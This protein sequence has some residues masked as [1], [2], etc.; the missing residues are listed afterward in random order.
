MAIPASQIVQVNPRLLTPGGTDLEFNGLFITNSD[1]IPS[2]QMVVPFGTPD[3]VGEYFGMDSDEYKMSVIY[4]QGYNNS[5]KKPRAIYFGRR[6]AENASAF[7]RGSSFK[8]LPA[9]TLA[10]LQKITDGGFTLTMDGATETISNISLKSAASLSDVAQIIQTAIREANTANLAWSGATVTYSSIFNA[11][12]VTTGSSGAESAVSFMSAPSATEE[13][14]ITDLS[15]ALRMTETAGA[16]QSAGMNAMT[17]AENMAAFLDLTENF[18]CLTTLKQPTQEDALDYAAWASGQGVNYLYIYWDND[19][20]LLQPNNETT[21]AAALKAAN[22]GATCGVW[23]KCDHAAF[24]MGVAA[25]I[26]WE[27]RNGTITFA[28]KSQD[29][30]A[31]NVETGTNA[32]NLTAQGMNFMGDYATRNDQFIFLYPGQMFGSW[33]WIDTY[34]NAVWLNNVLQVSLMNGLSQSP[35]TP[36]TNEGYTM[37]RA[38]CQDPVNRAVK[39]GVIEA[40]VTL[41]ESQKAQLFRETGRDISSEVFTNGYYL[42]VEDPSPSVRVTRDSPNCSLYFTYGGAIHKLVLASTMLS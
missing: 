12:M 40:G 9:V 7:L 37:V 38:W 18:V 6:V 33:S 17:V 26:D 29:G 25:S 1:F 5:F 28:F 24:I 23:D 21:I 13:G 32:I 30:L 27:R 31:A 15:V 42:I 34:L 20:K 41:S 35:R 36:Y 8:T 11:F 10:D 14:S 3:S 19:P 4:F 16:V 22:V 2:S 39:N